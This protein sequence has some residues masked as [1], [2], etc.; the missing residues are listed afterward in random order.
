MWA[1]PPQTITNANPQPKAT[2]LARSLAGP[3]RWIRWMK[4]RIPSMAPSMRIGSRA[5]VIQVLDTG[6]TLVTRFVVPIQIKHG[7]GVCEGLRGVQVLPSPVADLKSAQAPFR[8]QLSHSV[9]ERAIAFFNCEFEP[10][11][12]SRTA[13]EHSRIQG[14]VVFDRLADI[15]NPVAA[16]EDFGGIVK[17]K[18]AIDI[19]IHCENHFV[20]PEWLL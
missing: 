10:V 5:L 20:G 14:V 4:S 2:M 13:Q 12:Q 6:Q 7:F 15:H 16:S 17:I 1:T 3:V 8:N 18:N 9:G 11:K 19:G